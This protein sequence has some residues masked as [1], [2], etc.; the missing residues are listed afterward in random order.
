MRLNFSANFYRDARLR[1]LSQGPGS[2]GNVSDHPAAQAPPSSSTRPAAA[3]GRSKPG[4]SSPWPA[5]QSTRLPVSRQRER[6]A[7]LRR[8]RG[9]HGLFLNSRP[10]EPIRG[11]LPSARGRIGWERLSMANRSGGELGGT[12]SGRGGKRGGGGGGQFERRCAGRRGAA[13][14][15]RSSAVRSP[16]R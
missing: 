2:T 10:K 5:A 4:S 12:G 1:E 16:G 3:P 14:C 7:R 8:L 9:D 15:G 11:G 13:R 6:I